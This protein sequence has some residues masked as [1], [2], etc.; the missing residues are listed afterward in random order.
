M[1]NSMLAVFTGDGKGKTTAAIGQ[2]F[3]ALGRGKRVLMVQFIK[4]P[5]RSG[6][7]ELVTKLAAQRAKMSEA[8]QELVN[9][10]E[11]LYKFQIQKM[12]RGF[13]GILGD[14]LPREDHACAARE[15]LE[16]VRS[17][18]A[19]GRWDFIILDEVN[20]AV[21]LGLIEA[22]AVLDVVR[23]LPDNKLVIFTGR[24]APQE[25][26][27]AADLVTEMR[28]VKHPFHDGKEGR[29]AVEF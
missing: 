5:W 10:L 14:S 3:R 29:V 17:E 24:N 15:A 27:A 1:K 16:F 7:D 23:N 18:I 20:V 2:A 12:G 19:S 22:G 28:D 6:E 26:I 8:D 25:F 9:G 4:G 21:S 13:V 11:N